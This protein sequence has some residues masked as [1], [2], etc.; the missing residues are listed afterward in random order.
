MSVSNEVESI[1]TMALRGSSHV[2]FSN[3]FA[4]DIAF[5]W[6]LRQARHTLFAPT[7]PA[8]SQRPDPPLVTTST[9]S[10]MV[11][12][13]LLASVGKGIRNFDWPASGTSDCQRLGL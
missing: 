10:E 11:G 6:Y 2:D 7:L 13:S 12:L 1:C 9:I 5:V 3:Q 8:E 4:V